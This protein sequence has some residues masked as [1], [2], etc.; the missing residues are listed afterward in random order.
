MAR[1]IPCGDAHWAGTDCD[2]VETNGDVLTGG[3]TSAQGVDDFQG[4]VAGI[5]EVC[6]KAK[7]RCRY[8]EV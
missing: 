4:T 7:S 6:L 5:A 8:A 1:G 3:M 2:S